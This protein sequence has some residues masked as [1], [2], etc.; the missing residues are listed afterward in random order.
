MI[1]QWA[2]WRWVLFINVPIGIAVT[3]LVAVFG[4]ATRGSLAHPVAGPSAAASH[5]LAHGMSTAFALAAIF[6]LAALA[7]I[8]LLL[9]TP[10]PTV[11]D[12][13]AALDEEV[14]ATAIGD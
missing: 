8:A 13:P 11:P 10:K 6:D 2:S 4:T 14:E 1:T 7:V 5:A 9:R 12:T 3:V